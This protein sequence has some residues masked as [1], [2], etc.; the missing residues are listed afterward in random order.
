MFGINVE[1]VEV[2]AESFLPP[3]GVHR[4]VEQAV[5]TVAKN[6][7][8]ASSE[9]SVI[10]EQCDNYFAAAKATLGASSARQERPESPP[11]ETD[12]SASPRGP[13]GGKQQRARPKKRQKRAASTLVKEEEEEEEEEVQ[14]MFEATLGLS[15][16]SSTPK[17]NGRR[18]GVNRT[19]RPST[20]TTA[21]SR[22]SSAVP[23]KA[24][25]ASKKIIDEATKVI[26]NVL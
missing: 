11:G 8:L 15:P 23:K 13:K 18:G 3:K 25:K 9:N 17:A 22:S 6:T 10:K 26:A 7:T 4:Y 12:P 16:N 20:T 19:P 2:L 21:S 14:P 5:D 24:A 1:G